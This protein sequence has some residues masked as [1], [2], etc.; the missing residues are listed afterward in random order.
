MNYP[1]LFQEGQIGRLRLKNRT[2]MPPMGTV[3]A[4]PDQS[5]TDHY[6]N[7]H[8]QRAEGGVALQILGVVSVDRLGPPLPCVP[9]IYHDKFVPGL[10]RLANGIHE[11]G[12]KVAAQLH[13]AGRAAYPRVIG[14]Q[15]VAPSPLPCLAV[16][17]T[18]R[19]LTV[20]EIEDLVEAFG[21]AALRA[22][23]AG[24]DAVEIHGAHGYLVAQFLSPLS[25]R[26]TDAYGGDVEGRVRFA[27]EIIENIKGKTTAGFP[28][29]FRISAD[30]FLEEGL[31]QQ[32]AL[33][34]ANILEKAGA[35]AIHVSAGSFY[36]MGAPE[37]IIAPMYLPRG[38]LVELAANMKKAVGV[39]VI[40]VGSMTG[41]LAEQILKDGRCDFVAFGRALIADPH[42]VRKLNE[43]REDEICHCI[44]CN[45]CLATIFL[46]KPL[47]C[48][49]NPRV[50]REKESELG[51]AATKKKF[52]V[53]GGGPA[54]MEAAIVA[55]MRGH[56]VTLYE[57]SDQLG[58]E[59][60]KLAMSLPG[61]EDLKTIVTY[62]TAM[63]DGLENVTIKL[64]EEVDKELVAREKPEVVVVATGGRPHLMGWDEAGAVTAH[65]IIGGKAQ[66][67]HKV[68]V[69]G[70]G[71]VGCETAH[72]LAEQGKDVTVIEMLD[73]V[74]TD[75][76]IISRMVLLAKMEDRGV[77]IVTK[78][79]V[80]EVVNDGVVVT[81]PQGKRR[82]IFA[83][84][85]V[86]A[87]GVEPVDGLLKELD[88]LVP[89]LY[90]CGDA[91]E[92]GTL[93][94]AIR[95]AFHLTKSR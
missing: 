90:A 4:A 3:L 70:G 95:A 68:I 12:G 45:G 83:D 11:R 28:V 7:Y 30:E 63:L 6:M 24:L 22:Q 32:E 18:P 20:R 13:H 74:A 76:D 33:E 38:P 52:M 2:I 66:A 37:K 8:F 16:G 73:D 67:G 61:K 92:Y 41:E 50:G 14:E 87:L 19:E 51:A 10:A 71:L 39:P 34:M 93:M 43:Q 25:N 84:T 69:T 56:E 62:R 21:D 23:R 46:F 75:M 54:G 29:I 53:I 36:D 49:V 26:R 27:R 55:G 47:A 79:E 15:S 59:Q 82:S 86:L 91:K 94:D 40:A 31:I 1:T 17:D 9:G 58:G 5:I 80:V 64:N 35:D 85:V 81:D 65:D 72:F 44:R 42:Y 60:L 57:R 88:G 89:E 77:E 48:T 78:T